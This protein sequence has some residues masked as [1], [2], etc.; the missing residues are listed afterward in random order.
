[1]SRVPRFV[2]TTLRGVPVKPLLFLDVDGVINIFGAAPGWSEHLH[3]EQLIYK[4]DNGQWVLKRVILDRRHPKLLA[5]LEADFQ[6]VWAT[7]WE[8]AANVLL[9]DVLSLPELP[10][11][12]FSRSRWDGSKLHWKTRRLADYADGRPFCW[13]DDEATGHDAAW[14]AAV[15]PAACIQLCDPAEGLGERQV[16][17]AL[18]FAATHA[19]LQRPTV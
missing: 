11:V 4:A 13:I 5:M 17:S 18:H 19:H 1:M 8:G 2:T 14:L 10:V 16:F 6:L 9:A 12:R 15:N 7:A 3:S